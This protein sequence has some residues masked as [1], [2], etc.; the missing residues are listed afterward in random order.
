MNHVSSISGGRT[1]TVILTR[2]LIKK[3]GKDGVEYIFCDTGAEHPD[4]YRFLI[5]AEKHFGIKIT[6]LKLVLPKEKGVGADYKV[7]T[8]KEIRQDYEAWKQLTHKYGN[9]FIPGGKTC[10]DQMKTAIHVK[11]CNDKYGNGNYYTWLG[12]RFEEG[13]R[14]FGKDASRI[15]GNA[16]MTNEEKTEFYLSCKSLGVESQLD[17]LFPS[18]FKSEEDDKRKAA[19]KKSIEKINKRGFRFLSELIKVNKQDVI[20]ICNDV[21]FDLRIDSHL[22]NCCF[23]PEKPHAVI[24]LA[25]KDEPEMAKDF[26]GVVE[27]E[28]VPEKIK[29]NGEVKDRLAMYR[30]GLSFGQLY[31]KAQKLSREDILQMS[32]IGAEIAKRNP[33]SSGE[34]SPFGDDEQIEIKLI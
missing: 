7:C 22:H 25:I 15:L 34:C 33:C 2:E 14:I 11:Y 5:D 19:I 31:D 4:T 27:D 1:S 17:F 32:R 29:R 16:G 21:E 24:M 30:K 26:L 23:C 28:N 18:M 20:Y 9:P 10:T 3:Y 8:T 12:Y 13:N 6:C